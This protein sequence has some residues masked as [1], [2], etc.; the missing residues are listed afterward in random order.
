MFR[1]LRLKK[2]DILRLLNVFNSPDHSLSSGFLFV[3]TPIGR[4]FNETEK[5]SPT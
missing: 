2:G 5:M 3:N 4:A 1:A